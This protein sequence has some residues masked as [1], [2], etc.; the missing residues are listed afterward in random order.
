MLNAQPPTAPIGNSVDIVDDDWPPLVPYDDIGCLPSIDC[1]WLPSWAGEFAQGLSAET[2]T[3]PE[4]AASMVLGAAS[5][6]CARCM[7]VQIKDNYSEVCNTWLAVALPPGN[8]KSPVE[9]RCAKPLRDYEV[10]IAETLKSR[11]VERNSDI[12]TLRQRAKTLRQ[13]AANAKGDDFINLKKQVAEAEEEIPDEITEPTLWSSDITPEKLG[14]LLAENDQSI[15]WLSAEAGLFD[16]LQGRYSGGIL[17]LDLFLKAY[18][19]DPEKVHRSGRPSV[20][21]TKPRLTMCLTPQPEALRGLASV[22]GFRGRGLLGRFWFF[23]P[24]S[25]LGFRSLD[26]ASVPETVT[27]AYHKG[28]TKM[29]SWCDGELHQV[30]LSVES[31]NL[32]QK[33]RCE[34]EPQMRP[35]GNLSGITDWAAKSAGTVA[36]IAAVIHAIECVNSHSKPWDK[37]VSDASMARA[38]MFAEVAKEHALKAFQL[39]GGDERSVKAQKSLEWIQKKNQGNIFTAREL[40]AALQRTF[41]QMSICNDVLADLCERGYIRPLIQEDDGRPGRKASPSYEVRSNA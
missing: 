26:G 25:K 37:P 40:F 14:V 22:K 21:L 38:L 16:L 35:D 29:L 5:T 41:N 34:L 3:P 28:I 27:N 24:V 36:R 7:Q 17:N 23:L 2:E 31:K 9:S 1:N 15:A 33:Y 19:G 8:L 13:K 12:A 30:R 20:N 32:W 39:M 11:I 18:S 6:A 4:L 10:R